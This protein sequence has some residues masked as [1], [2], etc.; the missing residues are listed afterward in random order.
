M[1]TPRR[2]WRR[3]TAPCRSARSGDH[4]AWLKQI[5]A[6]KSEHRLMPGKPGK[7]PKPQDVI[8][9]VNAAVRRTSL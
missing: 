3:W 5:A 9:A 1:P 7:L 6:W 4:A 2:R 8:E